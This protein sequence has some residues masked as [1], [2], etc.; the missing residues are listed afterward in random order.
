MTRVVPLLAFNSTIDA[1]IL[2]SLLL[3]IGLGDPSIPPGLAIVVAVL[4]A[5]AVVGV[6][7]GFLLA[8][9]LWLKCGGSGIYR[10][11]PRYWLLAVLWVPL[12]MQVW[13]GRFVPL[14][15]LVPAAVG[16]MSGL[17]M[18]ALGFVWFER[19]AVCHFWFGPVP[20]RWKPEWIEFRAVSPRN[21][22]AW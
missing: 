1:V 5:S 20:T 14:A 6:L 7:V 17:G 13:L 10:R 9:R 11:K 4:P 8:R 12:A 18:V 22:V 3:L 21:A 2:A 19:R 15:I 16:W